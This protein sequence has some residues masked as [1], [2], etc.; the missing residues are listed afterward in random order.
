MHG[1]TCNCPNCRI[2][3][4]FEILEF[5]AVR[6]A[7]DGF[8]TEALFG[9]AYG[10]TYGESPF[11]EAEEMELAME[12][13]S[14]SSEEELEQFLGKFLKSAWKGIKKVGRGIVKVARPFLKKAL[15]LVGGALGSF[16]PIPGVGTA[17]GSAL[18]GALG[19]A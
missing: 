16:I 15:P 1:S 9:E 17:V 6:H 10:K 7:W 14:V 11:S 18:G 19:K 13:L 3:R 12:L 5:P 8:E 4:G 2:E